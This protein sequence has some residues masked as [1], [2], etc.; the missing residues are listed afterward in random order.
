MHAAAPAQTSRGAGAAAEP[1]TPH[2]APFRPAHCCAVQATQEARAV[3]IEDLSMYIRT[4]TEQLV[5]RAK[6]NIG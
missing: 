3:M 4:L 5:L 6:T 2:P 1:L